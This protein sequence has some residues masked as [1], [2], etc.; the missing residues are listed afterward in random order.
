MDVPLPEEQL[1]QRVGSQT[2][3][4]RH[5]ICE[6]S[7]HQARAAAAAAAAAVQDVL[8]K[9]HEDHVVTAAAAAEAV[10]LRPQLRHGT[11]LRRRRLLQCFCGPWM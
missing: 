3:L 6:C 11:V 10:V 1:Q 7:C 2:T 5:W 4:P 8:Q 9:P